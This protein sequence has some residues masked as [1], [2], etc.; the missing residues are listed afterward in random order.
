MSAIISRNLKKE[1]VRNIIQLAV[2]N[3]EEAMPPLPPLTSRHWLKSNRGCV[4]VMSVLGVKQTDL[5]INCTLI[6]FEVVC[7]QFSC[8]SAVSIALRIYRT[9]LRT[10]DFFKLTLPFYFSLCEVTLKSS[11]LSYYH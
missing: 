3:H 9:G 7:V 6:S 4:A 11:N 8:L 1:N 5:P 2:E 10:S